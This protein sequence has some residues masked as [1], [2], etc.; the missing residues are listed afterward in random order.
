MQQL[1]WKIPELSVFLDNSGQSLRQL[2]YSGVFFLLNII[3][4]KNHLRESVSLNEPA[5]TPWKIGRPRPLQ[6]LIDP[7]RIEVTAPIPDYP[8]MQFSID[9]RI[10]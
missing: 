5:T 4:L 10:A 8:P 6:I 3:F 7:E 1:D 9:G 2:S